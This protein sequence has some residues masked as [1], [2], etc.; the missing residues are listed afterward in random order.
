MSTPGGEVADGVGRARRGVVVWSVQEHEA[1]DVDLVAGLLAAFAVVVF[2]VGE[3]AGDG[4][5]AAD[6]QVGGDGAGEVAPR[7]DVDPH[8]WAPIDGEPE[9]GDDAAVGVAAAGV[10]DEV[11]GEVDRVHRFS[12]LSGLVLVCIV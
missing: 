12:P 7:F 6:A 5:V 1:V 9:G 11:A 10:V 4:D 8:P 2:V 3:S